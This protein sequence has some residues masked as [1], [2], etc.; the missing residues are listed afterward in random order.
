ML[1]EQTLDKLNAMKIGAMADACRQQ[2]QTDEPGTTP[3]EVTG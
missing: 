3:M 2:M 1:I